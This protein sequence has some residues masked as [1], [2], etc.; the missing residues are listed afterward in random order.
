M[1]DRRAS[2]TS[3]MQN[4][5][6]S[7]Q[8]TS[9]RGA[10]IM[11]NSQ[12]GDTHHKINLH[13]QVFNISNKSNT[14]PGKNTF[15][16]SS[17]TT[18]PTRLSVY[19]VNFQLPNK[20]LS[21]SLSSS[22]LSSISKSVAPIAPNAKQDQSKNIELIKKQQQKQLDLLNSIKDL[23]KSCLPYIN[24]LN[25]KQDDIEDVWKFHIKAIFNSTNTNESD[26]AGLIPTTVSKSNI[27]ILE[28]F[29]LFNK[30]FK[31]S[32]R[33]LNIFVSECCH[34]LS[35]NTKLFLK[36][37]KHLVAILDLINSKLECPVVYFDQD[38]LSEPTTTSSANSAEN[39]K[40][41]KEV[42]LSSTYSTVDN[43]RRI[44]WEIGENYDTFIYLKQATAEAL[45]VLKK[46]ERSESNLD[47]EAQPVEANL[48]FEKVILFFST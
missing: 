48:K 42:F 41:K 18:T 40:A 26:Q 35:R 43:H 6:T 28:S 46:I 3:S 4:N 33:R 20:T 2:I 47:G 10:V 24:L 5:E 13:N 14:L 15:S 22:S 21:S 27:N 7:E 34:Y 39:N 19:N 8:N 17:T 25:I 11:K 37:E 16:S 36:I 45:D 1:D 29:Y 44:V 12:L 31:E 38:L 32:R 23:Y 30:L 9:P